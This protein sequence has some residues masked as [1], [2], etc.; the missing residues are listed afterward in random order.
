MTHAEREAYYRHLDNVVIL[1]DNISTAR[2]EGRMEGRAEGREEGRAE[3]R[4]EGREEGRAEGR[5]EGIAETARK[6]KEVGLPIEQI[7]KFTGL[8]AE[9]I[10]KL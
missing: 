8:S 3:G 7:S 9:E 10:S 5:A 6:M 1:Q 4:E 2:G